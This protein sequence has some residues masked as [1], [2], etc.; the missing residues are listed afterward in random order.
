MPNINELL[1]LID[2]ILK[3]ENLKPAQQNLM[4]RYRQS[5]EDL[6]KDQQL[7][8]IIEEL[9]A[10]HLEVLNKDFYG[11]Q[12]SEHPTETPKEEGR[13]VGI[14]EF[15]PGRSTEPEFF[16]EPYGHLKKRGQSIEL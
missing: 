6:K 7:R 14:R 9:F 1:R 11:E 2:R 3:T 4:L 15:L 12:L 8:K 16:I 5:I 13:M 10:Q